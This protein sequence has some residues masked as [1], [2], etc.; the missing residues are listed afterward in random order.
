[1]KRLFFYFVIILLL[2]VSCRKEEVFNPSRKIQTIQMQMPT[3]MQ[4]IAQFEYDKNTL[5]ALQWAEPEQDAKHYELEYNKDKTIAV[6]YDQLSKERA[7]LTYEKKLLKEIKFYVDNQ[8]TSMIK[9]GRKKDKINQLDYIN[10]GSEVSALCNIIYPEQMQLHGVKVRKD[11]NL[12]M[13][14]YITYEGD[15]V[16]RM[17][18]YMFDNA[19]DSTLLCSYS[20]TYDIY[21]NPLCGLPLPLFSVKGYSKNNVATVQIIYDN[22][23][24]NFDRALISQRHDYTYKKRYP[25]SHQMIEN[26]TLSDVVQ[27]YDNVT[28]VYY[29]TVIVRRSGVN[30][31]AYHVYEYCD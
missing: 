2:S 21:S 18:T 16:S 25:I 10:V 11:N 23:Y 3:Q 15:N 14:Q 4:Q 5:V 24:E 27:M 13:R 6:I 30:A 9:V 28:H 17:R 8:L 7:E 22:G 26:I 12:Y 31:Q 19:Q 20:Y 29:D 1:M